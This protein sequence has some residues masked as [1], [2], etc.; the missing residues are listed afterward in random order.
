M[1]KDE[2]IFEERFGSSLFFQTIIL[3]S[4]HVVYYDGIMNKRRVEITY[5]AIKN[6]RIEDNIFLKILGIS[7]I[8]IEIDEKKIKMYGITNPQEIYNIIRNKMN[9]INSDYENKMKEAFKFCIEVL[10]GSKNQKLLTG[11]EV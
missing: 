2:G 5:Q 9:I 6:F 11:K 3:T 8:L 7:S 4:W 1:S 10:S